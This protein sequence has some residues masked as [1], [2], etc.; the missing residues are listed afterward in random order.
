MAKVLVIDDDD[1]MRR[2][3]VRVLVGG[4]H[5]VIE[6]ADGRDGMRL[7]L[8]QTPDVVVSDIVMPHRDG[9]ETIS[10]IRAASPATA[11]IAISGAGRERVGVY[12]T[13]AKQLGADAIL[14]KPFR[15]DELIAAVAH[16]LETP[17]S[18]TAPTPIAAPAPPIREIAKILVIED[19]EAMRRLIGRILGDGGCEVIEAAD[20]RVGMRL[21][22]EEAPDLVIT[23]I[24]MPNR[25]G[26]EIIREIR[27]SGSKVG[28]IAISGG[29][30]RRGELFLTAAKQFGADV[31]L[32]KPFRPEALRTAVEVLLKRELSA[33]RP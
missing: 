17:R 3:V 33:A 26:I 25:D 1:A 8:E 27:E 20:G 11:I 31:I 9:I 29:G 2:M 30:V 23:D 16:L 6:A 10:G 5:Q 24:V 28:L 21:F 19:D 7:F 32:Q 18:S 14:E 13:A 22:R 12:L 15:P 4:G